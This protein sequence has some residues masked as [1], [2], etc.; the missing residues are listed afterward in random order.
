[1]SIL[2]DQ[3]DI[4]KSIERSLQRY[5]NEEEN[6]P[7]TNFNLFTDLFEYISLEKKANALRRKYDAF[8]LDIEICKVQ[9]KDELLPA[10]LVQRDEVMEELKGF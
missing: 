5:H 9:R 8:Q 2:K 4:L 7:N 10:L 6:Y 1:M 3:E